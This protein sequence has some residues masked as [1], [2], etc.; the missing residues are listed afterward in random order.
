MSVTGTTLQTL[1]GTIKIQKG[2]ADVTAADTGDT[3]TAAYSGTETSLTY[4]WNKD[5]NA[6]PGATARAYSPAEAGDYTV[7]VN[8]AGY[9]GKTS[10]AVNVTAPSGGQTQ[11]AEPTADP[12]AGAVASGTQI[13]LST[14]TA[15][16][17]IYYTA[18]GTT[19]TAASTL[20]SAS[21]KPT[22]TASVT[23]KAI[24]VKGG[25]TNSTVFTAAYT[26]TAP[27]GV[28]LEELAAHITS[29]SANNAANPHT[30]QLAP[31][32]ISGGVMSR[33]MQ[34][35]TGK[36]ITLDLSAC[37]ATND[38]IGSS[39][40]NVILNNQYIVGIILPDSLTSIGEG[41]FSN[42]SSLASVTIPEGVTSIG[43]Y[44]FLNCSSLASVTIP[45]GLTS[46]GYGAFMRCT[47]LASVTI[48]GRVTSFGSYA[49]SECSSLVSVTISE[50]VTSIGDMAFYE[51]TSLASVTI[52]DSVTS[53]GEYA[54]R[55]CSSLESITIPGRVT[56]IRENAFMGCSSLESVTIPEGVTSIGEYAFNGCSSL[57][58]VTIP[59]SV[60]S[61]EEDAFSQ[62]GLVSVTFAAGSNIISSGFGS[63][64]PF[65]GDLRAKY[66]AS[67]GGAGTYTA[68]QPGSNPT[69]TKQQ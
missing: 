31:V 44:A 62:S 13:T 61:I 7:T 33:I 4:Q 65:P 51:C 18:D 16:A 48:P 14:T 69:W 64:R 68:T 20:Y 3:L 2:G 50:G 60:T 27:S 46:I 47:S 30:V 40:M 42:C 41:A 10:A 11:V 35:V 58:S 24:A 25:M 1:A 59:A 55:K 37:S 67:G 21:A 28:S 22:I 54:F 19:P 8:A 29:L 26:V 6:I 57:E 52:P 56:S 9:A 15:G 38:T 23:I 53:I 36:Y 34:A 49:F 5:G 17:A 43:K 12:P 66:L 63:S 32:N 45:E 39:D